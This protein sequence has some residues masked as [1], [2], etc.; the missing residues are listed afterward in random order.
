MKKIV[1]ARIFVYCTLLICLVELTGIAFSKFYRGVSYYA[2][3]KEKSNTLDSLPLQYGN[4]EPD[5]PF[6]YINNIPR[7]IHPYFGF[8]LKRDH[9][10]VN[11]HGFP[12]GGISYPYQSSTDEFVIGIFGGSIS[13][14][15]SNNRNSKRIIERRLI[16][17]LRGKGYEKVTVLS[18]GNG[19]WRQP[20]TFY[21]LAY[22]IDNI[23]MAIILDG[24]NDVNWL[25]EQNAMSWPLRFPWQELYNLLATPNISPKSLITLG[26]LSVLSNKLVEW[27]TFF[28]K[29]ILNKSL[30]LHSVWKI[31]DR[32]ISEDIKFQDQKS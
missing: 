6:T 29:P 10:G 1:A 16:E 14:Q 2:A 17:Y 20:Q 8:T 26:E 4:R 19:G 28:S 3:E 11:N 7:E 22:Y 12:T 23:D 25:T 13:L 24:Y 9:K 18:F 30:F 5:N 27:T 21:S 32:I 31:G 15:L